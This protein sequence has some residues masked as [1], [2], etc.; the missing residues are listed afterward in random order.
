MLEISEKH[1][2]KL[3][4]PIAVVNSNELAETDR[5]D[6]GSS[7]T[8]VIPAHAIKCIETGAA[9]VIS[10][11]LNQEKLHAMSTL[12]YRAHIE[13]TKARPAFLDL[14]KS[15][16]LSW[17]GVDEEKPYAYLREVM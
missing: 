6:V 9:D 12:A 15:R 10:S 5:I 4:V 14:K 16:K 1:F 8:G 13:V 2:S 7:P 3:I 11:P 17:V